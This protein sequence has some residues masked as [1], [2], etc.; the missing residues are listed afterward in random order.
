MTTNTTKNFDAPTDPNEEIIYVGKSELKRDAELLQQMGNEILK[1]SPANLKKIPMDDEL[2]RAVDLAIKVKDKH[3][4]YKRQQQYI[5]K[6]MRYIDVEPI[7][8]ALGKVANQHLAQNH[9]FHKL[10][11]LRDNIITQGDEA[12]N[13]VI[14][15]HPE[16]DFDRSKLRQLM[17]QAQKELKAE[18][19]T[20]KAK[21]LIFQYL[22]TCIEIKE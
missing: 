17:R 6:L 14:E 5:G 4:A 1:L 10:E 19:P 7:R 15:D 8:I 13:K 9:H 18:K 3:I 20:A 16:A 11:I 22:K 21:K 2:Q 12:I